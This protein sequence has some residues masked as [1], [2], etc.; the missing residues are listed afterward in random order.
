MRPLIETQTS[1][2]TLLN[3]PCMVT[4]VNNPLPCE[5]YTNELRTFIFILSHLSHSLFS[6]R[7]VG[8]G[9]RLNEQIMLIYIKIR[10]LGEEDTRVLC[11]MFITVRIHKIGRGE[12][13][14]RVDLV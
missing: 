8:R 7:N 9:V 12:R 2:L 6:I 5:P 3:M 11:R 1:E 14:R 4:F 13:Y 10:L